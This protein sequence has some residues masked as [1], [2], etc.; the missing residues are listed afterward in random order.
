[1]GIGTQLA[2]TRPMSLFQIL[3]LARLL[4]LPL[5]AADFVFTTPAATIT[6]RVE[7]LPAYR[8]TPFVLYSGEKKIPASALGFAEAPNQFVGA[9]AVIQ[10]SVQYKN[11]KQ[12]AKE[13]REKV[14][15]VGQSAGLPERPIFDKTVRFNKGSAS[16]VQLFGYDEGGMAADERA[17]M[18]D[19]A[20]NVWRRFRQALYLDG[21]DKPFAVLDWTH[22]LSEIRLAAEM[23]VR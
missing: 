15:L 22:T 10:Y 2:K 20:P 12:T 11:R 13:I 21:A 14:E 5:P 4:T 1:M 9:A 19:A 6:L 16:D 8:G 18:R 23:S 7:F 17:A 3:L